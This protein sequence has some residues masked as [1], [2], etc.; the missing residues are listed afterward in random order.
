MRNW[1]DLRHRLI[2]ERL[3]ADLISANVGVVMVPGPLDPRRDGDMSAPWPRPVDYVSGDGPAGRGSSMCDDRRYRARD[4]DW[5][6]HP[7]QDFCALETEQRGDGETSYAWRSITRG[8]LQLCAAGICV[9]GNNAPG[10]REVSEPHG[11]GHRRTFT[12]ADRHRPEDVYGHCARRNILRTGAGQRADSLPSVC[13]A[14]ACPFGSSAT[15]PSSCRRKR[16]GDWGGLAPCP[17]FAALALNN[18]LKINSLSLS[19]SLGCS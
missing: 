4:S 5:S 8:G 16:L 12:S 2:L 19:L 17:S 15:R 1:W 14:A 9:T 6:T 3:T 11:H 13:G 18:L 10:D 7:Q